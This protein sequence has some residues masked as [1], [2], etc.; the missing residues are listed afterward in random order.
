[1][2]PSSDPTPLLKRLSPLLTDPSAPDSEIL[3]LSEQILQMTQLDPEIVYIKAL[4]LLR[5]GKNELALSFL[6]K[7]EKTE[8]QFIF[9]NELLFLFNYLKYKAEMYDGCLG[10]KKEEGK[11]M[12][13]EAQ[14][15]FKE[16]KWEDAV[17]KYGEVLEKKLY[18]EE[19]VEDIVVNLLCAS[20]FCGE[21]EKLRAI[22]ISLNFAKGKEVIRELFFNLSLN[23]LSLGNQQKCKEYLLKFK[24]L[25]HEEE[26][27][28]NDFIIYKIQWDYTDFLTFD[29]S[30][31]EEFLKEK[32]Y[33]YQDVLEKKSEQIDQ[34][35]HLII[36]NNLLLFKS[37]SKS[38]DFNI[39]E[40][41]KS[42][43]DII[44]QK[45]KTLTSTQL[46]TLKLNKLLLNLS[47]SRIPESMKILMDIENSFPADNSLIENKSL[48]LAKLY[49]YLKTKN[50]AK[51]DEISKKIT[52]PQQILLLL[53]QAE[54][55]RTN[56][57]PKE[58]LDSLLEI[59]KRVKGL[60]TNPLFNEFLFE[61]VGKSPELAPFIK[62][63]LLSIA[64]NA[65]S[66]VILNQ[67]ADLL[68]KQEDYSSAALLYEKICASSSSLLPLQKLIQCLTILNS[69]KLSFYISKLP[70]PQPITDQME[71]KKLEKDFSTL[72]AI[73]K[74]DEPSRLRREG[75]RSS[76]QDGSEQRNVKQ[77][78]NKKKKKRYPKD[79]DAKN[80]GPEP[81]PERWLPKYQRSKFKKIMKKKGGRTQG[82]A[83]I[84]KETVASFKGASS[85]ANQEI[86][87]VKNKMKKKGK[88]KKK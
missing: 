53:T 21:K 42:L 67:V 9:D 75:S 5:M 70:L 59:P 69:E 49:L 17:R 45:V 1:M 51:I 20:Y 73:S 10:G 28:F 46:F 39:Q 36:K 6:S 80:P 31:D 62:P 44:L 76:S 41:L 26:E 88:G 40:A 27:D 52:S 55:A 87:S 12:V 3:R 83:A 85:T 60:E 43:D 2:Q 74:K 66:L 19:N 65:S 38:H 56:H 79:F 72:K 54:L 48:L 81:D 84:G 78:Q 32:I 34:N 11:W 37:I 22:E 82:D 7:I 29:A 86:S 14:T 47:K 50:Q 18:G 64:N 24:S 16:G 30:T 58:V 35:I 68:F 23:Y 61:I 33:F 63:T 71:L 25:I 15:R 77:K 4:S 8:K 57:R 13:L